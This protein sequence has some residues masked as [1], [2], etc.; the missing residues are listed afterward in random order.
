MQ[1]MVVWA[2]PAIDGIEDNSKKELSC[3]YHYTPDMTPGSANGV[4]YDG[5]MRGI[6]G[7]HLAIVV[8]G[9]AGHDVVVGDS[10]PEEIREMAKA[11]KIDFTPVLKKPELA[12]LLAKDATPEG[13]RRPPPKR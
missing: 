6:I 11:K 7:N 3:A 12:K 13:L 5:V 9:R 1:S 8:E 10:M 2:K 4:A